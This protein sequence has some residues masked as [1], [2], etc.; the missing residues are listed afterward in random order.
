MALIVSSTRST[1][2]ILRYVERKKDGSF[3]YRRRI[4]EAF[5]LRYGGKR[6]FVRS[7]RRDE[8]RLADLASLITAKLDAVWLRLK[9]NPS[10][11]TGADENLRTIVIEPTSSAASKALVS[12]SSVNRLKSSVTGLGMDTIPCPTMSEALA[13]YLAMHSQGLNRKF[14]ADNT[15]AVSALIDRVGDLRLS[16]YCRSDAEDV[17][18][19]ALRTQSSG[20]VRRRLRMIC[21]IVNRAIKEK[22]LQILN[23]FEGLG[24]AG[25][26]ED[27]SKRIPF[28]GEELGIISAACRNLDDDIRQIIALQ[29]DTGC[30]VAEVVGLRVEDVVLDQPIPH[31]RIRPWGKVRT[32]KTA[33]SERDVPLVGTALWAAG[34]AVVARKKAANGGSWLFPRYASEREVK[35]T[36]ASNTLNKWLRTLDVNRR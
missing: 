8:S 23:P 36:H 11:Q 13:L 31:V 7:L 4:P 15:R 30:R 17:R 26:G 33:A 1:T 6:F 21:A 27:G 10:D 18:D 28:T 32:L 12:I 20:T 3:Q 16:M 29:M 2:L 22:Q 34:R 25:E 14:A 5:R 35:A 9:S 19:R 24:I